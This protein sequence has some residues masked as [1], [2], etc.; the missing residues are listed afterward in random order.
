MSLLGDGTVNVQAMKSCGRV[1]VQDHS[2]LGHAVALRYKPEGCGI[3]S[4]QGHRDFSSIQ[5]FRP[6]CGPGADSAS[7]I[8]EYQE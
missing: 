1:E 2:L 5:S 7:N 8:N 3:D 4:Q 6:H